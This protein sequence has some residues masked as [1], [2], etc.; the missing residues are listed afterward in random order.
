MHERVIEEIDRRIKRLEAEVEILDRSLESLESAPKKFA[1]KPKNDALYYMVF[2]GLW[3]L[4]GIGVLVYLSRSGRLPGTINVPLLPYVLIALV[5]L[6]GGLAY[7]IWERR[8]R[9][10]LD[11]RGELEEKIRS[12]NLVVKFF[13]EPL[14]KALL[15]DDP[16]ALRVLGDRLLEDPI[17]PSAVEKVN[18]GD[19]KKMAYALYLY[20]SYTPEMRDEVENLLEVLGNKPLRVL[21]EELLSGRGES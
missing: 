2:I 1:P 20:A 19:P 14:K 15:E 13:Y 11:P 18:E 9:E 21:L 4:V 6:L 12:A 7:A 17:L 5:V 16:S 3:M 8:E 10:K